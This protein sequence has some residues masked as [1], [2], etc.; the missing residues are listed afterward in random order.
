MKQIRRANNLLKHQKGEEEGCREKDKIKEEVESRRAWDEGIGSKV[1]ICSIK[2]SEDEKDDGGSLEM[3]MERNY[4]CLKKDRN[5]E[6][7]WWGTKY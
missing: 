6:V 2:V 3:E 7:K 5:E 1:I 4:M